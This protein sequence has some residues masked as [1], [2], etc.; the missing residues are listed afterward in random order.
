MMRSLSARLLV[1]TV[2]FVMIAEILIFVPSVARFRHDWLTERLSAAHLAILALDVAPEGMVDDRMREELLAHV[3]AYAINVHRGGA[4][5]VLA[6]DTPPPLQESIDLGESSTL[7]LVMDALMV[8]SRTDARVVR[9]IGPSP[10]NPETIIEVVIEERPLQAALIDFGWRVFLLSLV[11]SLFT[12]GLVYLSLHWLMVRPMRRITESMTR[13]RE[14]PDDLRN[15]IEP[16]ARSDE[17]GVAQHEL[18]AMQGVLRASLRQRGRLAALG[19]GVAK[20]NHDLRGIL[21]SALLVSDRLENS[22]DPEVRRV[23]PTLVSAIDRAVALCDDTLDYVRYDHAAMR[24]SRFPIASLVADVRATGYMSNDQPL[25]IECAVDPGV[26]VNADRE[27]VLR[28]LGNILQNSAEAGATDVVIRSQV[29]EGKVALLIED[30]GPGL[31]ERARKRLFEPFE[32]SVRAGGTGLGL[33]IAR[34]LT[35]NHGGDLILDATGDSG[36]TFRL[37]LPVVQ[38]GLKR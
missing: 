32:G 37:T 26:T 14:D 10:Q 2:L 28:I 6:R 15:I 9:I 30:N 36:T 38:P 17:I 11:I 16:S 5:L 29:A 21:S 33:A 35:R 19:T 3:G 23:T 12:A 27:Q 1:L 24:L 8:L 20:I 22:G 31:P 18:A 25:I 7:D 13:F 34:E 4:K